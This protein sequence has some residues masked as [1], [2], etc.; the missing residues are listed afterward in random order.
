MATGPQKY[1]GA[2]T[3]SW[4]QKKWG[5]DLMEVNVLVLHTTEG[6]GLPDYDGGSM[7]PNL[8]GVADMAKKRLRWYQHFDIDRSSRALQ[9]L[10]GGVQ[11]NTLNVVQLELDG[12]CDYSKREKWGSRVAGKDYIYWG[13]PPGWALQ[14][15][16]DFLKWLHANHGVPLSGPSTWLTY[17]PDSRRPGVTPASYGAS[18]ARMSFSAWNSFRGVC[19]HEQVPENDHGDPG[20]LPFAKLIALAKGTTPQEEDVALTDA[21]IKKIA[22]AVK[23]QVVSSDLVAKIVGTDNILK[24]G[25]GNADNPYWAWGSFVTG[26]YQKVVRIETKVDA[27]TAAVAQVSVGGVDLDA[28]AVKVAAAPGLAEAIATKVADLISERLAD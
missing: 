12:T 19:G 25:D 23:A 5:G 11:T 20:S 22:D 14:D 24:A 2:S 28:L 8:T 16:A 4:W 10:S 6:V 21:E 9:N 13:N 7:A 18:P 17:G 3:S 1:P 27:L 15:V 26:E